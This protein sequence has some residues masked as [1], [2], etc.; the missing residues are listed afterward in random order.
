M[1]FIV[2][3]I[4][5]CSI[6]IAS[7]P[8]ATNPGVAFMN[9]QT[10]DPLTTAADTA[11]NYADDDVPVDLVLARQNL[12]KLGMYA[13]Y[14]PRSAEILRECI[15]HELDRAERILR[16]RMGNP[17]AARHQREIVAARSVLDPSAS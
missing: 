9:H 5:P 10:L 15:A 2:T 4:V 7:V 16:S 11:A 12:Q 3:S 1:D 8:A 17:A 14:S 6:T 13:Q